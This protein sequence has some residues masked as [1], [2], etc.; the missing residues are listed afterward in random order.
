MQKVSVRRHLAVL[1]L[2]AALAVLHTWPL[3]Q[4]PGSLSRHD[5]GDALLNEW[6]VA[7]VAH[8]LP[9][10]PLHL[11]DANI[12]FPERNTLA[13]SEH[14]FVQGL[15]GAP[16][17]WAGVSTTV[18]HNLLILLGL[19]LTGWTMYLVMVRW[20]G[21]STAAVVSG[22]LLAFNAYTLTRLAH[23]QVMHAEFL[24]LA[25]WALDRL[26]ET[27]RVRY[28]LWLALFFTLQSLTS[29]Y[30][31]VFTIFAL[32]AAGLARP[33][34]W[35]GRRRGPLAGS[36]AVA[37]VVAVAAM[38]P[39]LLPYYW[40]HRDQGLVRSLEEVRHFSASWRDYLATGGRLHYELWS[41]RVWRAAPTALFP[42]LA[43]VALASVGL[44]SGRAFGDRR[45]R[46]WL[47]IGAIGVL[48]SLGP[49]V[50]GYSTLYGVFPLLQGIRAPVRFGFLMLA[51]VAGL[52]GFGLAWLRTRWAGRGAWPAI[53]GSVALLLVTAEAF[54]APVVFRPAL[55]IPAAYDVLAHEDGAVIVEFPLP[56]PQTIF[57]NAPYMLYS[58][59]HWKPMLNGYS[60]FMPRSYLE[61]WELIR[62]FPSRNA[63]AALA[64]LGVTHIVVH[65]PEIARDADRAAALARVV[66]RD[67]VRIYRLDRELARRLPKEETRP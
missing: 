7:W 37:A 44:M 51:G 13:F 41:H 65:D 2:F 17:L 66:S 57:R 25:V 49:V 55:R 5:N 18:V 23:L 47:A 34:D 3:A 16:L 52:A 14:L 58:T 33:E 38:L 29:N 42:G 53:A 40:A 46:M 36:L 4:A 30:L 22:C 60:G 12:F 63:L 8:Q 62:E 15:L 48:L 1:G 28:A 59:R 21:D 45:Q 56:P 31:L 35:W 11:F 54:R 27:P 19:T 64:Q 32:A 43:A 67:G 20:T 39:F 61:H 24:P 10:D 6:A 50:P 26:V 9:R